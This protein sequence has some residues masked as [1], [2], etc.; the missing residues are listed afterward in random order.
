M[1]CVNRISY[2]LLVIIFFLLLTCTIDAQND[3]LETNLKLNDLVLNKGGNEII[4]AN[5]AYLFYADVETLKIKD[6]IKIISTADKY[7]SSLN[8]LNIPKPLIIIKTKT[9]NK[10]YQEFY[11]YP[12]DS[13]Y[14]FNV[15]LKKVS[16]K[17][18]GNLYATINEDNP[19]QSVIAYNQF[20]AYTNQQGIEVKSARAGGLQT[21]PEE[22]QIASSGIL[23]NLKINSKGTAVALIYYDSLAKNSTY[24][25]TLEL[26]DL[27]NL[28]FKQKLPIIGRTK[29][30]YFSEDDKYLIL[31]KDDN[32]VES[33]LSKNE[34]V[35]V[36]ETSSLE[37][38]NE[39]PDDLFVESVVEK[40]SVWK[41]V[42]NEIINQVYG[43]DAVIQKI[44]SNLI[45]IFAIDGFIKISNDE[46]LIY[47][48]NRNGFSNKKNGIYKYSLSNNAIFSKS[49][50][51][52]DVDTIFKINKV[53]I[54]NNK[55]SGDNVQLNKNKT[56]MQLYLNGS[57]K[58]ELWSTID[59]RKLYDLEF[60]N[61]I[62]PFLSSS[63]NKSLIFESHTGKRYN[64]FKIRYLNLNS[65]I[66]TNKLFI[67]SEFG[68]LGAKCINISQEEAT[69]LCS[70][71]SEYLWKI[72]AE[73][74]TIE[75]IEDYSNND[76]YR[77]EIEFFKPIP[78]TKKAL[79]AIKSINVA[80]DH[81]VTDSKFEGFKIYN[82]ETNSTKAISSLQENYLVFPISS[83]ELIFQEENNIKIFDLNNETSRK[84]QPLSGYHILK[85]ITDKDVSD[86]IL[87][88]SQSAIDSLMVVSYNSKSHQITTTFKIPYSKG[89]FLNSDGFH[90][91][92]S[93]HYITYNTILDASLKWGNPEKLFTHST[94]LSLSKDGKMLFRNEWLFNLK[95]LELEAK[96]PGFYEGIVLKN[97]KLFHL[98]TKSYSEK[99]PHFIFKIS[100][101]KNLETIH[102]QSKSFPIKNYNSPNTT[103]FSKDKKFVLAYD[104][105]A[106]KGQTIYLINLEN[107]TVKKKKIKF[108]LENVRFSDDE[109]NLV[110]FT[111]TNGFPSKKNS[112][113]FNTDTFELSGEFEVNYS[114]HIDENTILH[115][116]GE[117]LI[118]SAINGDNLVKKKNYFARKWLSVAKYLDSKSLIVAGTN[119]GELLFWST[120]NQSPIKTIKVSSSK[121]LK[122]EEL[123]NSLFILSSDS[124]I[125]IVDLTDLELK[126]TCVFFEKDDQ[127]SMVWFTPEG[128]FKAS[129]TDIRNFHFVKKGKAF[130]LLDYSLFLNR[131]DVLMQKVG[132]TSEVIYNR[133]KNAYLKRLHRN[134]YS[135]QTDFLNMEKPSVILQ[136]RKV[137]PSITN[138]ENLKLEIQN[139]SKATSLIIYINGVPIYE[140]NIKNK[141]LIKTKIRLNNG[142][143]RVSI[144]TKSETGIESD[145]ITF[146]TKNVTPKS[147]SKTYYVG[148][149]VSKY[150][151]SSMDLKYADK[152]VRRL[153]DVFSSKYKGRIEIDTLINQNVTKVNV[154]NLK[155]KLKKTSID[156]TVIISFSGHG[157]IGTDNTFYFGTHDIDFANPE[158][159]GLNYEAIQDL[160]TNIPARRKL[161]L[162]DACHSGELVDSDTS[163]TNAN[164]TQ[165]IPTGAKGS[166][167]RS[168][169]TSNEDTFQL[170][171]SLFYD[172]DRGNGSYVISAA[173]GSEFAY[174]DEQ[175]GNGVFTYSF[176]NA[177]YDLGYDM[178]KGKMDIPISKIKKYVYDNVKKLT[179]NKQQPTS[180]A[181]NLEWDWVLE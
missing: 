152:D 137:I 14:F 31:K 99:K 83:T 132:F 118:K 161:L 95:T 49:K 5:N 38:L 146:E 1:G 63:G 10:Y 66:S 64:E 181:E 101:Q 54:S 89:H 11:E 82:F 144:I 172:L 2:D 156:D 143:N 90:Y 109:N 123:N 121:I 124:E 47:G 106:Y 114:D 149:G 170:M 61:T 43:K 111:Q 57:N 91:K 133:Y 97:D 80:P 159:N 153:V 71:S 134:N 167:A 48:N 130:P 158:S 30:I 155:N 67:D 102:W 157:L 18:P 168:I 129:K 93:E 68:G 128:Y 32:M 27:P 36:Y 110:L 142:I 60:K 28:E 52:K 120:D 177:L 151:D 16:N 116:D 34:T 165:N 119:N 69:W 24:H 105:A 126:A 86:I 75:K 73:D 70:D 51:V 44:W 179:N 58:L 178:W 20:Y 100:D 176:I 59:K 115:L 175:W 173:A 127:V 163:D 145:P 4:Y 139:I 45:P 113:I 122:I 125:S 41:Q 74:K 147:K 154:Q 56:L 62:N 26:R 15:N 98:E 13:T 12:E 81:D 79:I 22:N 160:L 169:S 117:Y 19:K 40:G 103:V 96:I 84:L 39:I 148:I 7:I 29:S 140:E 53:V 94:D 37:R 78:E 107:K 174:E 3:F 46:L 55:V 23:R 35:E 42:K 131:P 141:L 164:V 21:F 150:Q 6:S 180:R 65:G 166:K 136:N 9:K 77:T 135:E 92:D 87:K 8:Y 88:R 162:L 25:Y 108:S 17:F 112:Q 50:I 171:Q 138:N 72:N 33:S 76:Y 104:N 85:V